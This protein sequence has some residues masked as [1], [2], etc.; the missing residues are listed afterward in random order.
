MPLALTHFFVER[1]RFSASGCPSPRRARR[2]LVT[3]R[4][5]LLFFYGTLR[6]GERNHHVLAAT[7]ARF[8]GRAVTRDAR[9]LVDLGPYP[10]LLREGS[11]GA[12]AAA[13]VE[14]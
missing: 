5:P 1:S 8:V 2:G 13:P 7:G 10:A 14:G 6:R 12:S 11:A 3:N 9:R 4:M